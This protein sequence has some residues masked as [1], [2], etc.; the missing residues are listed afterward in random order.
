M[1]RRWFNPFLFFR[2]RMERRVARRI[3]RRLFRRF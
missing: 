1:F 3:T 2:R